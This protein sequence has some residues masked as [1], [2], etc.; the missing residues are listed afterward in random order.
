MVALMVPARPV[1]AA[2][3]VALADDADAEDDGTAPAAP[4]VGL[5]VHTPA[6]ASR[7]RT[8]RAPKAAPFDTRWLT[9]FFATGRARQAR[10]DFRQEKGG[11][12]ETGFLKAAAAMT[13]GSD[14][15]GA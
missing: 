10:A 14:E 7:Q 12:A 1:G 9:P 15:R 2:R 6:R 4:G 13:A 8:E 5:A 3:S 11:A